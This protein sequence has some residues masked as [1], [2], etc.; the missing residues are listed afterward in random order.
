MEL[1]FKKWLEKRQARSNL[2]E[3]SELAEM[4]CEYLDELTKE[5]AREVVNH[6]FSAYLE[7]P[8][9]KSFMASLEDDYRSILEKKFKGDKEKF[10]KWLE[11]GEPYD[12]EGNPVIGEEICNECG[13][14]VAQGKGLF[15]NRTPSLDNVE[16]R[17]ANG[18][19]F[20]EGDFIC[21]ECE[22]KIK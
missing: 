14:S 8:E 1:N 17:E 20:P 9:E 18:K 15:V 6:Y 21:R 4:M 22:E 19:P 3:V 13:R 11:K 10:R 16:T 2:D 5:E 7:K 12:K